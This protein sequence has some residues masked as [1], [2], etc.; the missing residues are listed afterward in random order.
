MKLNTPAV[1]LSVN[2]QAPPTAELKSPCMKATACCQRL[3]TVWLI[4][5]LTESVLITPSAQDWKR[6]R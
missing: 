3:V 1:R 5:G 4:S 2:F 6:A